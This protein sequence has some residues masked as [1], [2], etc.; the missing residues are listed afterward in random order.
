MDG[1]VI[2]WAPP[3]PDT[4][5]KPM[6]LVKQAWNS[7]PFTAREWARQTQLPYRRIPLKNGGSMSVQDA[8]D[9]FVRAGQPDYPDSEGLVTAQE[10]AEQVRISKLRNK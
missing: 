1:A 8:Y 3:V 4:E 2:A 7:L 5:V 6:A 9:L 10:M